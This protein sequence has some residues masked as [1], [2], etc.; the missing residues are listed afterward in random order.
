MCSA[1]LLEGEWL[2]PPSS[3]SVE[4]CDNRYKTPADPIFH[5]HG[6]KYKDDTDYCLVGWWRNDKKKPYKHLRIIKF[7]WFQII[8]RNFYVKSMTPLPSPPPYVTKFLKC[9]EACEDDGQKDYKRGKW[10][11][12]ARWKDEEKNQY[13]YTCQFMSDTIQC[14]NILRKLIYIFILLQPRI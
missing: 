10:A 13:I 11:N 7:C 3:H 1:C 6:Q 2:Q 4:W 14:I 12:I 9:L 8:I 5:F